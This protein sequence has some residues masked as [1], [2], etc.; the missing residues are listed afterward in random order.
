L[1][2]NETHIELFDQYLLNQLNVEQK[3]AFE[4]RLSKEPDLKEEFEI[5]Q[6]LV[7]GIQFHGKVELKN[8]L[9]ENAT[10]TFWGGNIWPKQMR[11][12]SVAVFLVFAG[13]YALVHFYLQPQSQSNNTAIVTEESTESVQSN[14]TSIDSIQVPPATELPNLLSEEEVINNE[15]PVI[16]DD[17]QKPV[18][19][20]EDDAK[21]NEMES[22]VSTKESMDY[23]VLKERK[24][25]DTVLMAVNVPNNIYYKE[26]VLIKSTRKTK[27]STIP[28]NTQNSPLN[29]NSRVLYADTSLI[30]KAPTNESKVLSKKTVGPAKYNVEFWSSPINFKGYKLINQTLQLYGLSNNQVQLK[31]LNNQLYLIHKQTVYVLN[32]CVDGCAY[33]PLNDEE[34]EI[35]LL[36]KN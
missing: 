1:K 12:A 9:K 19:A 26:D 14:P 6:I 25:S 36:N 5:H 18:E 30:A 21:G 33:K 2:S 7:Q 16:E 28:S 23:Q 13:L 29:N 10:V 8:F 15:I 3:S 11:I 17:F 4:E 22:E 34:I 27:S 24:F 31:M 32:T 35:L 20:L